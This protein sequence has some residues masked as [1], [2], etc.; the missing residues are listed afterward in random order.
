MA[1]QMRDCLE[2]HDILLTN[3]YGFLP[4]RST[5]HATQSFPEI[6]YKK[7]DNSDIAQTVFLDKCKA[8]DTIEHAV[9]R[10]KLEFYHFSLK[11][12]NFLKSYLSYRKQFV[13]IKYDVSSD[14]CDIYIGVPQGSVLGLLLFFIYINDLVLIS[15]EFNYILSADDH[16]STPKLSFTTLWLFV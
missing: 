14:N 13:K 8:F 12:V 5:S 6:I 11:S 9:L 4:G 15:Q 7:Q 3:Q 10:R 16:S 2:I 1:N